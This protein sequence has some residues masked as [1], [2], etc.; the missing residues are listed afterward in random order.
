[1]RTEFGTAREV[2]PVTP[3]LISAALPTRAAEVRPGMN[4]DLKAATLRLVDYCR[5]NDWAGYDPY[6]ALNSKVFQAL[7]LLNSRIPRL[8]LT[9]ALKRSPINLRRLAMIPKTQNPKAM[10]LFL[11][12]LLKLRHLAEPEGGFPDA[13][14]LVRLMIERLI[15]LRSPG[16]SRWCWGYS[17]PWQGRTLLVPAGA[18][19]LVCTTFV[20]GALLDA[21]DELQDA[22]CLEMATGAAEYI[23]G[24]LYWTDG[25]AAGFSYPMPGLRGEVHNANLLAAALLCRVW[26]IGGA[27]QFLA[28]AMKVARAS[29]AKQH[30]DGSWYYGETASQ[31]WIDNFHTGYNLLALQAIGRYAGTTEFE[32]G[33]RRGLDFYRSHFFRADGAPKYFHDRAYPLDIHSVAQSILTLVAFRD[34]DPGYAGLPRSVFQWAMKHMWDDRGFFYY[35]V[36]R[37]GKIRTSYMRWSQA[38]MLLAM[39]TLLEASAE[40]EE[41]ARKHDTA[42]LVSA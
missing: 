25:D 20:A 33:M 35:R 19:N 24:E 22:R 27:E 40:A 36:L 4:R 32:A 8:V 7:P 17:F 29:A 18:P 3:G 23:L 30:A 42:A 16:V 28:P 1:L 34:L 38:W 6:D 14:D 26:R 15:A 9:Q 37:L 21:Y 41:H 39:A 2:E 13:N 10:A 12:A 31:R 5:A 11:S